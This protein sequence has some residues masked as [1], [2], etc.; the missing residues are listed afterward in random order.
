MYSSNMKVDCDFRTIELLQLSISLK[1]CYVTITCNEV[2]SLCRVI[3]SLD[4]GNTSMD[5]VA[6]TLSYKY[7]MFGLKGLAS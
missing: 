2:L 7:T 5:K 4:M 1:M 6:N 3:L